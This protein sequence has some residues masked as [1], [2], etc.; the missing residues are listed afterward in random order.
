MAVKR[1]SEKRRDD[2]AGDLDI[3][4]G[5]LCTLW[6]FCNRLSGASLVRDHQSL[7][8]ELFATAV[9][10]AEGWSADHHGDWHG[11]IMR[12][13]VDRYGRVV[14]Q[15]DFVPL[16]SYQNAP[17]IRRTRGRSGSV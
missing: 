5:D 10:R 17:P 4:L 15:T 12:A 8:A 7:T 1:W 3:L 9:L 2:L 13:F 6:G 16:S 11:R 14:S